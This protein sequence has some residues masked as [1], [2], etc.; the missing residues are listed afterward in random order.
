MNR[1][2]NNHIIRNEKSYYTITD[3]I[4]NNPANWKEDNL[5]MP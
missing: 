2:Y 5:Y 4:R 1:P 3:Y